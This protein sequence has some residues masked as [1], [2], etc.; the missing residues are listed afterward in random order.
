MTNRSWITTW[1]WSTSFGLPRRG[2]ANTSPMSDRIGN[3][4]RDIVASRAE[5]RCEY[6]LIPEDDTFL[7]C[8]VDHIISLKHG[9]TDDPGNLAFACVFCNRHKG[10]DIASIF[11]PTGE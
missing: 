7:G 1:S 4:I 3:E 10:S 11:T 6:C 8:E 2:P 9:G 5:R